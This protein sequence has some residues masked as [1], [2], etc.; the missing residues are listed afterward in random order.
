MN[1]FNDIDG[2]PA[3]GHKVLQ[4]DVLKGDWGWDGFVV[5]DWASITLK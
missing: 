5:S 2:I 4:R 1:A 3:T